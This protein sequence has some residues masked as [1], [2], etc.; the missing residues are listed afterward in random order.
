MAL[1]ESRSTSEH[2]ALL[3]DHDLSQFR[4]SGAPRGHIVMVRSPSDGQKVHEVFVDAWKHREHPIV[5]GQAD[6]AKDMVHNRWIV[7]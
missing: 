3:D 5:I 7:A 2:K 4:Q 6:H 1:I